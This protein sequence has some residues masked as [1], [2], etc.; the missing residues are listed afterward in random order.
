MQPTHHYHTLLAGH[1]NQATTPRGDFK[2]KNFGKMVRSEQS[3]STHASGVSR[4]RHAVAYWEINGHVSG[5]QNVCK[6]FLTCI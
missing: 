1:Q 2:S 5:V 3:V 4:I 6:Q